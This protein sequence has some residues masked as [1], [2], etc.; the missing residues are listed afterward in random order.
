MTEN[1]SD[2]SIPAAADPKNVQDLTNF[3]QI[4]LQQMQDKF[5]VMS[6]QIINRNILFK[7]KKKF[8]LNL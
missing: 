7:E 2:F 6:D 4:T 1:N 5:Q 8:I 3:I